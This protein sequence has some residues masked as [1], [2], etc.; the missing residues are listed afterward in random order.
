MTT[1]INK[2]N[3]MLEIDYGK[4]L[5]RYYSDEG[6]CCNYKRQGL[7]QSIP[8]GFS[9]SRKKGKQMIKQFFAL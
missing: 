8:E 3:Y 4:N 1:L 2:V 7:S 9:F 5:I 6:N